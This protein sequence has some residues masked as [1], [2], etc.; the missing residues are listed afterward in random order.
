MACKCRELAL[1][2]LGNFESAFSPV[3]FLL[4]F[5]CGV[6]AWGWEWNVGGWIGVLSGMLG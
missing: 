5:E 6:V 3:F 2:N 4:C 1:G